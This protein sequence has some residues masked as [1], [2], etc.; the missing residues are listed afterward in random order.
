MAGDE[1]SDARERPGTSAQ[2]PA[3]DFSSVPSGMSG[4]MKRRNGVSFVSIPSVSVHEYIKEFANTI[5][6]DSIVSASRISQQRI[7]VYL[8]SAE[9]VRDAV[10]KGFSF[11][12]SFV[13]VSPLLLPT[14][15]LT[16]SNVYPEVPNEILLKQISSFC[17]VVS[18]VRAI[19]LGFKDKSF[20]HIL[21]FRRQVQV[22]INPN[23]TPPAHLDFSFEGAKYRVFISTDE[24]RCFEC[25]EV[26]HFSRACKKSDRQSH[27]KVSDKG[28]IGP[29]HH[30]KSSM[31]SNEMQP[32]QV[33]NAQTVENNVPETVPQTPKSLNAEK[34]PLTNP[35]PPTRLFSD[36]VAKRK[37]TPTKTTNSPSLTPLRSNTPQKKIR[38]TPPPTPI[39]ITDTPSTPSLFSLAPSSPLQST[40]ASSSTTQPSPIPSSAPSPTPFSPSSLGDAQSSDDDLADL[41]SSFPSSQGPL[42]EKDLMKFLKTVKASKKPVEI[43]RK[44]TMNLPGLVRQLVPLRNTPAFKKSTQQRVQKLI[45]RLEEC[46]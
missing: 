24:A 25:G 19:P 34:L 41:A 21:S 23:V 42:S 44:F 5:P 6:V 2:Q 39:V 30:P 36:I 37:R 28:K 15:R 40:P 38:K 14:T 35:P 16:L 33:E 10:D 18:Q 3:R 7:A 27:T 31:K 29:K 1:V 13:E 11:Q 22:L 43:A 45:K 26:G 17:K 32:Q 20:S 9:A 4:P 12:N 8:D 46:A